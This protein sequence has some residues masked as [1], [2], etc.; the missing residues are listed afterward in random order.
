M[1]QLAYYGVRDC[2]CYIFYIQEVDL[3][4]QD[5]LL[6]PVPKPTVLSSNS[7]ALQP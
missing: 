5:V 1:L 3:A 2:T 7:V 4:R 6:H